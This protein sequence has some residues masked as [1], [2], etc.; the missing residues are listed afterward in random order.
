MG[1]GKKDARKVIDVY[2]R[3]W[4]TQDRAPDTSKPAISGC[5]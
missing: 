2:T 5:P 3:A 4:I 1:L